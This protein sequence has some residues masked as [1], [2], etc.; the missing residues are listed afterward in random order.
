MTLF[1]NN[2]ALTPYGGVSYNP[3]LSSIK[4]NIIN[5]PEYQ[6]HV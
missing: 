4:K 6:K 1:D 2:S 3:I 5:D